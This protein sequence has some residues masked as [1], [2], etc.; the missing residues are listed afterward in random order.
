MA[1]CCLA[2]GVYA[3]TATSKISKKLMDVLMPL[4]WSSDGRASA[5]G[6][7]PMVMML[8]AEEYMKKSSTVEVQV[9]MQ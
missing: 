3:T 5:A 9:Q 6:D 2:D 7:H 8:E 1:K 4:L